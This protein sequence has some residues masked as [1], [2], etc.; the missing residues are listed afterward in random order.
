MIKLKKQ[1]SRSFMELISYASIDLALEVF[2]ILFVLL[3]LAY[4]F[5]GVQTLFLLLSMSAFI[6]VLSRR[7]DSSA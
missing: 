4:L 7:P 1:Q 6:Y 5:V 2:V 3:W